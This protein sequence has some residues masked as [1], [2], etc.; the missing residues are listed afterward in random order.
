MI[1]AK[2]L[3]GSF[4]RITGSKRIADKYPEMIFRIPF[5]LKIFPDA[6]IIFLYRSGNESC[7][8]TALWS[9]R[10]GGQQEE[11]TYD[12]WGVNNRKFQLLCEQLVPDNADLCSALSKIKNFL[13]QEDMAAVEWIIS[14]REGLKWM[15]ALPNHVYGLRYE[16]LASNPEETLTELL[17]NCELS[18]DK[19]LFRY[20]KSVLK[21]A[22][23]HQPIEFNP[24]IREAFSKTMGE[25]GYL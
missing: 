4:L 1:K 12:W 16:D 6:K 7:A 15:K 11:E 20:A 9:K 19:Q 3:L 8:S 22:L 21:P 18:G 5:L 2:K 10:E 23:K 13:R 25:L 14:M 17:G 24:C